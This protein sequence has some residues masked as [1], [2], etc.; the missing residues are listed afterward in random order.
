MGEA[1]ARPSPHE[2]IRGNKKRRSTLRNHGCRGCV[3][4]FPSTICAII[5]LPAPPTNRVAVHVT[6]DALRQIRG[7]HPWIWS[8]S[9]QRT[10]NP[11][12]AGDLAVVFDDSRKFAGIGLWD[13]AAPIP[14]RMFHTGKQL[15]VDRDFFTERLVTA[16]DRRTPL[17]DDPDTTAYRLVHGENDGLPG[18][19]IDRYEQTLVV[20]LDTAAWVPHLSQILP[21]AV[22]LTNADRVVM[23]ASR[24][25][26]RALPAELA[27]G[28]TIHG[29]PPDAPIGFLE[30][31]LHFVADV[32]RG[33]KTGHFLDQRD[34][35]QLVGSQA[36]DADV[37][38]VFCNSGGFTVNA[39]AAQA[40]SVHSVDVSQHAIA[41]TVKHLE[42]N[43]SRMHSDT[44][45]AQTVSDAFDA[46]ES[47][48]ASRRRFDIVIVDPPSFAPNND[49]IPAA[50]NAYRRLS[51]EAAQLVHDGGWLFQ[52]SCSS[53]IGSTRFHDIV[54]R[55][56]ID[57]GRSAGH[58]I[59][60]EHALDH[61][62][63]FEHGAYLKAVFTQLH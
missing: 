51:Q 35:R 31:G 21:Q 20:K 25:A 23:R 19:V 32:I 14:V 27:D 33:Q 45:L 39:A 43:K 63:G 60:T 53:R 8:D 3:W 56:I 13:P 59:R 7:G 38:D 34:N 4:R 62:I 41:T 61:P 44:H 42:M 1:P 28:S 26:Q 6:K 30:N 11:G 55:G 37:L 48:R 9:V 5:D 17:D 49:A 54:Q 58:E 52:A 15:A 18:L 50:E 22:E 29:E 40:R 24:S 36:A 12:T 10:N 47:L 2:T 57:A 46:I 16:I